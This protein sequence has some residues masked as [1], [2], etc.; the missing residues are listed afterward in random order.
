MQNPK[1]SVLLP[2]RNAERTVHEAIVSI[3]RQSYEDWELLFLDD[4][5]I[6]RTAEIA[7][8]FRDLR[9]RVLSDGVHR[10]RSG[11]L[12]M[13]MQIA[14][15]KYIAR[16]DADDIAYPHRLQEQ[17]EFLRRHPDVDVV[18]TAVMLFRSTGSAVGVRR[19]P[20]SHEEICARPWLRMPVIHA[21]WIGQIGWFRRHPY[22]IEAVRAE[23][24]ALLRRTY[25]E[26]RFANIRDVL[27]G[28]REDS[29]LLRQQMIARKEVCQYAIE[30]S[31]RDRD[32]TAVKTIV[33]QATRAALDILAVGSGL[34]LA[35]LPRGATRATPV[36]VK[37]WNTV[38]KTVKLEQTA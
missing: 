25:R 20:A 33:A 27:L 23:D 29:I 26:S 31:K 24:Y 8:Q 18:G 13:A 15:G 38:W 34:G 32:F 21:T 16:M 30:A 1:I 12:N 5:S 11:Q 9:I 35:I 6:D 36:E 10:G 17:V 19:F 14:R 37:E 28:V 4:G 7:A 3:L 2:A 22:P